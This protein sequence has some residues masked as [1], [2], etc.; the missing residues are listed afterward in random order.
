MSDPRYN[1]REQGDSR[2]SRSRD[3]KTIH[4]ADC[5]VRG[6]RVPWRWADDKTDHKVA[7]T[8][9]ETPWLRPCKRCMG[10]LADAL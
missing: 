9:L 10:G 2:F 6:D 5:Q 1:A 8:I 3:G 4:R 7:W